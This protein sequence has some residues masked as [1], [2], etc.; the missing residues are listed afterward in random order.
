[1]VGSFEP[2]PKLKTKLH[3]ADLKADYQYTANLWLRVRYL[4]QSLDVTDFSTDGIDPDTM[5]RVIGLGNRSPN[6]DV[7]VIGISTIYRF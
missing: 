5:Q 3:M 2:L 4:Y 7:H 6:Y 1:M